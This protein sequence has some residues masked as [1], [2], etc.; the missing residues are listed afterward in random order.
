MH[1]SII[2]DSSFIGSCLSRSLLKFQVP[3]SIGDL[4]ASHS[5]SIRYM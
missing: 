3:V 5:I 1:A 2:G 4:D